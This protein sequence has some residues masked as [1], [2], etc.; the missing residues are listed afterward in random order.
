MG[1]RSA[2]EVAAGFSITGLLDGAARTRER[3]PVAEIPVADIADH[4]ANVAYSMDGYSIRQLADSIRRDGLT[5]LPLVRKLPGG[6]W[7]M[8]SGHRRKA[9]YALLAEGD[10]AF[11]RLPCRVIEGIS[12]EQAV[13]LLHTANYFVRQLTVTERAAATEALGAQAEALRKS[14]PELKGA[15]LADVKAAI[16]ERQ[17][18]RKVSGKTIQ[19]EERMARRIAESLVPEWAR[20]ADSGDLTAAAIDALCDMGA[21][22]QRQLF[23]AK[24]ANCVSKRDLSAYACKGGR[25]ADRL[26]PRLARAL[27]AL[28][29]YFDLPPDEA[30]WSDL[31]ALRDIAALTAVYEKPDG[32]PAGKRKRAYGRKS[33]K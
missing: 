14:D 31:E 15:R 8:V 29:S 19:R 20:L 18:G 25:G 23:A 11:E 13:T 33:S 4:P 12:D 5:D 3:F 7:Q 9:A 10:P 16:I 17:T 32:K 24:P 6:G 26:D 1:S 22:E 2:A 27:K 30:A 21:D 28:R